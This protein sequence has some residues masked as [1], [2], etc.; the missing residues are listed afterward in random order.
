VKLQSHNTCEHYS[1]HYYRYQTLTSR[2]PY[3]FHKLHSIQMANTTDLLSP[4]RV[5]SRLR[6]ALSSRLAGWRILFR[7]DLTN[8][9][10]RRSHTLPIPS[11]YCGVRRILAEL[12]ET[13]AEGHGP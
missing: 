8:G 4:E 5:R 6:K 12:P 11:G 10:N 3:L 7:E 13:I 2:S 1:S 9:R